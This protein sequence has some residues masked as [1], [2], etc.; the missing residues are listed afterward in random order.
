MMNTSSTSERQPRFFAGRSS[1]RKVSLGG[2]HELRPFPKKTFSSEDDLVDAAAALAD[3]SK[4]ANKELITRG[5]DALW[6][7]DE[8]FPELPD[9]YGNCSKAK[10]SSPWWMDPQ[11]GSTKELLKKPAVYASSSSEDDSSE[12]SSSLYSGQSPEETEDLAWNRVR[13]VSIDGIPTTP[14]TLKSNVL[15]SFPSFGKEG[16]ELNIVSPMN[17]P[18]TQRLP[19]RKTRARHSKQAKRDRQNKKQKQSSAPNKKQQSSVDASEEKKRTLTSVSVPKGKA[20]KKILRRK[21]SWKNYPEVRP[22]NMWHVAFLWMVCQL[23]FT[24]ALLFL[25]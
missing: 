19:M 4:I 12:S 18:V 9:L 2:E 3:L 8:S 11:A 14:K 20:V 7:D 1:A 17:S 16:G 10:N 15:S 25:H 22:K 21:F 13:S 24:F 5:K 6:E 23:F